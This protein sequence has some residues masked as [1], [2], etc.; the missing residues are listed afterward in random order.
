[1]NFWVMLIAISPLS[2][3]HARMAFLFCNAVE[4]FEAYIFCQLSNEY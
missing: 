4:R 3:T 2:K 1:M